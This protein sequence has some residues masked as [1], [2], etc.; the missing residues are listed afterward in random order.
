M[1]LRQAEPSPPGSDAAAEAESAA[2]SG[3]ADSLRP[4]GGPSLRGRALRLLTGREHSR[5]ELHRKLRPHAQ[6]AEQ[7]D[8]LLDD[9]E[10]QGLL[11][12]Q[13]VVESLLHQRAAGHGT[14]RLRQALLAKGLAPA[15]FQAALGE[16]GGSELERARALYARRFAEPVAADPREL[17][18]RQRFLLARGFSGAIVRQVLKSAAL[19]AR[20]G[21]D[22]D[23]D[24]A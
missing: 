3:R 18:R 2:P 20:E 22:G 5:L 24:S 17:A 10:R 14:Q 21:H 11:S 8:T 16:L 23:E 13:R 1:R 12:A 7:L 19:S 6:S 4:A 15:D 9:L